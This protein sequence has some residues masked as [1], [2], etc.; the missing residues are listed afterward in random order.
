MTTQKVDDLIQLAIDM[1]DILPVL[2]NPDRS[3]EQQAIIYKRSL[4]R[5][6]DE[7][8]DLKT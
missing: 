2:D 6:I 8:K 1:D 7:I 5:L 3:P 4:Q